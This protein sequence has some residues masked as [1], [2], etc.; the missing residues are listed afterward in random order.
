MSALRTRRFAPVLVTD[1]VTRTLGAL[2]AVGAIALL[3]MPLFSTF[4]ELLTNAAMATGVDALLGAWVA[5]AEARLVHGV[6]ALLGHRSAAD[7]Q[8]LSVSDGVRGVTLF[9]SWNCVGWQTLL[10]LGVTLFTGLHGRHTARSKALV[11]ALGLFG[12]AV[13]NIV[14]IAAV[15]LVALHVGRLPAMIL[16]D[17]G[18]VIATVLFLMAFW[19]LAYDRILRPVEGA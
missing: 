13:L 12:I 15:G 16:H 1:D 7:G 5:P 9:I 19:S 14:R 10:F 11:V 4:G 3:V 8:L 6:F 17:H 18:T 2:L